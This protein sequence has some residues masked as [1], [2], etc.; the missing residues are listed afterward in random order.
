MMPESFKDDFSVDSSSWQW[1][2]STHNDGKIAVTANSGPSSIECMSCGRT[3]QLPNGTGLVP[4]DHDCR[5]TE[6]GADDE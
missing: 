1:D 5:P 2:K 3:W 6:D 4:F